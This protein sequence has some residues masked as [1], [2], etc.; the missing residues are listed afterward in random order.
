M[1]VGIPCDLE[2]DSA[3]EQGNLGLALKVKEDEFDL[4]MRTDAN[5]KGHHQ[6]FYF[7]VKNK[8]VGTFKFNVLNFTKQDSLYQQGM[9]VAVRSEQKS[10]L[11]KAGELPREFADWHQGGENICYAV[12][13][14]SGDCGLNRKGL[15]PKGNKKVMY[16]MLSFEYTFDYAEDV[17]RF[18]Y[19]VPYTFTD[20][21][22][23]LAELRTLPESKSI[24]KEEVLCRTLSGIDVPLLTIGSGD[25]GQKLSAS[26]KPV[27][28]VTARIHPGETCGSFIMQGFLRFLLSSSPLA[29]QLRAALTFKVVPML[30]VDGVL[31]GNYRSCVCGHDLNRKFYSPNPHLHPEIVALKN[32]L[33]ELSVEEREVLGYLDMHAHSK[34]KCVFIYGPYYPLHSLR[35]LK[36]RVFANLLGKHTEMFR[37][38]AC[39]YREEREKMTAAR[40]VISR[41][42]GIMNSF[43]IEAS[44]FG[45]LNEERKMVEFTSSS[46]ELMG[47]HICETLLEYRELLEEEK[48]N[49][50]KHLYISKNM[51]KTA[52]SDV[53]CKKALSKTRKIPNDKS[54]PREQTNSSNR[55][56]NKLEEV[57]ERIRREVGED[58]DSNDS[59]SDESE[60]ESFSKEEEDRNLELILSIVEKFQGQGRNPPLKVK[61]KVFINKLGRKIREKMT[62]S[63]SRNLAGKNTS[64]S[65]LRRKDFNASSS[66]NYNRSTNGA[67]NISFSIP[68]KSPNYFA[69]PSTRERQN[70]WPIFFSANSSVKK[71]R[72]RDATPL[73]LLNLPSRLPALAAS[74][75]KAPNLPFPKA[76]FKRVLS[77]N[78]CID[79]SGLNDNSSTDLTYTICKE[80]NKKRFKL[81]CDNKNLRGEVNLNQKAFCN[82]GSYF[83]RFRLK[84]A[85]NIPR[86]IFMAYNLMYTKKEPEDSYKKSK[87]Y[88]SV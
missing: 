26:K 16:Y 81:S 31:L 13:K 33:H 58:L 60:P 50:L 80:E 74:A 18:A 53:K 73:Q 45:F 44:F 63:E 4:L 66:G 79:L 6:W 2:F 12:S 19:S 10:S 86:T 41:E 85:L 65:K 83:T 69:E 8:R 76:N 37:F 5:T 17:V 40:L 56:R 55:V 36:V 46:Y 84:N 39:K 57:Y 62:L 48:L 64:S 59:D 21:Q 25:E 7:S 24:L 67:R 88:V 54:V 51:K 22:T 11:A 52:I 71:K 27:V 61:K 42:F 38:R 77:T 68:K 14:L 43:T 72:V 29:K 35:Y 82:K 3:F 47:R 49:R 23:L 34:K 78:Y 70:K 1:K 75:N 20:L 15:N 9:R 32:V 87:H 30:N 28:M